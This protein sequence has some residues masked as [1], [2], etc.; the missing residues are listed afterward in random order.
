VIKLL[1]TAAFLLCTAVAV[2]AI[3]QDFDKGLA[4]SQAGDY[5]TALQEWRPLAEQGNAQAQWSLGYM[6]GNGLGVIQDY[7]EAANWY[8]KAAEQ[9]EALAQYNLGIMYDNGLGVIQDYA[10]AVDWYRKAAEQG[11]A[12]A[13]YNLGSMY[14][15]GLGVIH[16]ERA[17]HSNHAAA[18]LREIERKIVKIFHRI[19]LVIFCNKL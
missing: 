6:Y 18:R 8:R 2:P 7:A 16:L 1:R 19:L 3:A 11:E 14:A 4:A 15:T 12:L 13:Q 9:G 5:A 17:F 10:E